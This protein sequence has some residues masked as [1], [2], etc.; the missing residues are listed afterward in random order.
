VYFL[1]SLLTYSHHLQT[2]YIFYSKN[3][4]GRDLILTKEKP[5]VCFG[6][7]MTDYSK[8]FKAYDIRGTYP[9][10]NEK[11]YYWAGRGLVEA[12][13]K[14]QDLPLRVN[15]MHDCRLTSPTLYAA[16]NKGIL[17]AGA[18]PVSLGLGTTDLLYAA[19]QMLEN[20]GIMVTA[21]HNPKDDNGLK[22]VKQTPQ[23]LGLESGL[24][25]VR[26]Y[27]VSKIESEQVNLDSL[28]AVP[29]YQAEKQAVLDYYFQ[30]MNEVGRFSEVNDV[31]ASRDKTY[32][33]VVD[34]GNGMGG[35]LMPYIRE[36]Y[37]HIHFI[38]LFWEPDGNF[39]NHPADPSKH[40]NLLDL[41]DK[42]KT[43]KADL[44]IA[45]D[46]DADRA[47]FVDETGGPIEG[48]YL[49]AAIASH[50][51]ENFDHTLAERFNPAIAYS[52]PQSRV[53]P[54]IVLEHGGVPVPSRQG[55]TYVKANMAK[56]KAVYGG[57]GTGH[58][59]F[60]QF[61]FMDTGGITVGKV[62]SMLILE[63]LKSSELAAKFSKNFFLSGEQ[64]FKLKASQNFEKLADA[65]EKAYP[66]GSVGRMDGISV[67]YPDWKVN[68]RASN[69]EPVVRLNIETVGKNKVAAKLAEVKEILGL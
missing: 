56:Y 69:T 3:F 16:L 30:V 40:A 6:L 8:L 47:Y 20:P 49:V 19:C 23:M 67:F 35:F 2:K 62:L 52:Q 10:I 44:G 31:L 27:V 29:V 26:D 48:N 14:P 50:F 55:H 63:G 59:Y 11:V 9:E 60:G 25:L 13:L 58:H 65:L 39:P 45:F 53:V 68:L 38:E 4:V 15:I 36:K 33:I 34:C 32:K 46:G 7:I 66:D 5:S 22:I 61:G 51:L 41:I 24:D 17:E 1:S 64:N 28:P 21:S 37:P 57:E 12:I 43:E 18:E 54:F 42:I